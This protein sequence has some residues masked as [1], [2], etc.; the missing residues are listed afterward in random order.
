M[1]MVAV[2]GEI[3]MIIIFFGGVPDRQ[4]MTSSGLVYLW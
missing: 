4:L 3:V 1:V 2:I